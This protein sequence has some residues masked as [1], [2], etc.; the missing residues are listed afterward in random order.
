[1]R[2]VLWDID[3]T[4][5]DSAGHGREAFA[6]AFARTVG[7]R[8][9]RLPAMAGRTDHEIGLET[10]A[11]NGVEDGE[12]VWPR[13]A[14][15]L[16]AALAER[17]AAMRADGHAFP[18]ACEALAVLAQT[19]GVVQSVLTGN[20]QTNAATKLG[21]FGLERHLDLAIGAYG[22]DDR[23]RTALVAVARSRF[24]AVHGDE[25]EETVLV[26]DTPL[27]VAAGRAAGARVVGVATGP[28]G[29][30]ELV[31]AGADP[32]LSDLR[33]TEAVLD[34]VLSERALAS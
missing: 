12:R 33:D 31:A 9:A 6:V 5:L 34:A 30:D 11:L 22:S 15:A 25:P 29:R 2:L 28:H 18:G 19:D 20:L 1:M 17:S 13:F 27:D 26:G 7:R 10:L 21:A 8:P 4:L 32:T 16:A 3:G 23:R 14:G 24:A